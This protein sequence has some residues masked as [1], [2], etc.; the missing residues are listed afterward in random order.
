MHDTP[1]RDPR[2]PALGTTTRRT[3]LGGAAATLA[4]PWTARA[5]G[6]SGFP[7]KPIRVIVPNAAGGVADLTARTVTQK[8]AERL[9]QSMVVDNRPSA[10]GIVAGQ[11]TVSAPADGYT[12][13]VSTNANSITKGLFRTLPFD[14][15]ADFAPV[16]LM[17]TFA[18]TVITAPDS[19][20]RTIADVLAKAKREPG[21][22]TIGTIAVGSTQNLSAELFQSTAGIKAVTVPFNGTPPLVTALLRKDVDIA[23]EIVSPIMGQVK[24]GSLRPLAVTSAA[25]SANLPDVPTLQEAGL[26][27]FDVSSWNA[28]VAPKDTP[29]PIRAHLNREL[30]A[31]LAMP[32]V[33]QHLLDVGVEAKPSTPEALMTLA[34]NDAERWGRVIEQAGIEKQ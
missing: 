29:E 12:L 9:G 14:P 3:L 33:R 21:S 18:I 4:A 34:T 20:Y 22:I 16:G 31:V 30:N 1:R 28:L 19:P 6:P 23:F 15:V 25:R 5:Q 32:D 26:A 17:G 2:Q 27:G 8:L 11:A 13:L 7:N 10:G 24:S